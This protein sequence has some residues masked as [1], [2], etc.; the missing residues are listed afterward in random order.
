[1]YCGEFY[2]KTQWLHPL[3]WPLEGAVQSY[4]LLTKEHT[5]RCRHKSSYK[6]PFYCQNSAHK[7]LQNDCKKYQLIGVTSFYIIGDS[8]HIK[9]QTLKECFLNKKE[10]KKKIQLDVYFTEGQRK[11]FHHHF[12]AES[13]PNVTTSC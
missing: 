11:M 6:I 5:N 1:M 8:N 13:H 9:A 3:N 2:L 12:S 10:K 7:T 4:V